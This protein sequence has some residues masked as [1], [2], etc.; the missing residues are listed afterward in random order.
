MKRFPE[1]I[2]SSEK[3]PLKHVKQACAPSRCGLFR[4]AWAACFCRGFLSCRK[5]VPWRRNSQAPFPAGAC[6]RVCCHGPGAKSVIEKQPAKA[7]EDARRIGFNTPEHEFHFLMLCLHYDCNNSPSRRVERAL[8]L[9]PDDPEEA[10]YQL[11]RALRNPTH[12]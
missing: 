11:E 5:N 10:L 2:L 1:C 6:W 7:L 9:A 8:A 4:D 12:E 3:H